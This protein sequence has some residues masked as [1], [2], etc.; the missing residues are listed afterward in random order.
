M[1]GCA[2]GSCFC[3]SFIF[4]KIIIG[5]DMDCLCDSMEFVLKAEGHRVRKFDRF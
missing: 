5:G 3:F 2:N 1:I 4:Q